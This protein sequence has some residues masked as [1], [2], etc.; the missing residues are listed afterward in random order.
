MGAD[1]RVWSPP[2]EVSQCAKPVHVGHLHEW[3]VDPQSAIVSK[4]EERSA[5]LKPG[6]KFNV[7]PFRR[8]A[9]KNRLESPYKLPNR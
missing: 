9:H 5:E 6:D 1:L 4:V 7:F 3:V 2:V 8:T